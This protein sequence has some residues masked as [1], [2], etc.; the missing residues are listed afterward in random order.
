MT[1]EEKIKIE[2]EFNRAVSLWHNGE[3]QKAIKILKKLNAEFP[4]HTAIL[5]MIGAIY[6]LLEDWSSSLTYY[7]KAVKLLPKSELLS[8]ALFHCLWH[9]E[10]FDDAFN[11]AKRFI[12]L[13]GFSKEYDFILKEL[14]ENSS[15]D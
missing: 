4:N 2:P 3:S 1:E 13:N 5:K 8:T 12:K 7:E 11:E 14:N 6:F 10:R 9:H 15:P